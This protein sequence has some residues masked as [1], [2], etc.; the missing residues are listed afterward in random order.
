M[1]GGRTH[2]C[3][4]LLAT[5]GAGLAVAGAVAGTRLVTGGAD[6]RTDGAP[7]VV[8][9]DGLAPDTSDDPAVTVLA[10]TPSPAR[11]SVP[12]PA[13]TPVAVPRRS[14]SS[15]SPSARAAPSWSAPS[16]SSSTP[17]PSNSSSAPET[18]MV[19]DPANVP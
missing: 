1:R 16:P 3:W 9:A 12:A 6:G 7:P 18:P 15:R 19:K 10:P 2:L 14:A 5:L 11:A 17:Q 4:S 13:P 8:A